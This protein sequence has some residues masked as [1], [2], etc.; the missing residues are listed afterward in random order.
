MGVTQFRLRFTKDDDNDKTADFISLYA[1]E[2]ATNAP[3]LIVE[4]SLP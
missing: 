1:G 2:D 4:Y 3:Q